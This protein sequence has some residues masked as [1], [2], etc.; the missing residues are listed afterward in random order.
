VLADLDESGIADLYEGSLG[1]VYPSL[2]EGFGLPILEAMACTTP[3]L[4]SA[5]AGTEEIAGG[6]AVLV[7]PEAPEA[8]AAGIDRLVSVTKDSLASAASY[9]RTFTWKRTAEQTLAVYRSIAT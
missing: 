4:T 9:A 6:H 3:V 7:E 2:L 8:I 1:L 5:R